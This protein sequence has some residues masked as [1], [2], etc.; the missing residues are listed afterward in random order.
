MG[1]T[2]TSM[3]IA[4]QLGCP[5]LDL[6][7]LTV[8]QATH[9]GVLT[10]S[11]DWSS[12][13]KFMESMNEGKTCLIIDALDEAPLRSGERAFY[14]FMRSLVE[15]ASDFSK[16]NHQ[17][18][19]LGRPQTV[20]Y[21]R[22]VCVDLEVPATSITLDSLS[23]E[24]SLQLISNQ[25]QQ[26][27]ISD[28]FIVHNTPAKEY[29]TAYL[30]R[31]GQILTQSEQFSAHD[32]PR[33]ADFLG[34]PPVIC[35]IAPT[36]DSHNFKQSVEKLKR[37]NAQ[38]ASH[39]WVLTSIIN[40]LLSR[41]TEKVQRHL[42]QVFRE[43][44]GENEILALYNYEEQLVRVLRLLGIPSEEVVP[45]SLPEGLRSKY[46]EA[47]ELF[48][49]DHPFLDGQDRPRPRNV[50]FSDHLRS[51]VN[52]QAGYISVPNVKPIQSDAL[53]PV[54]PFYVHFMHEFTKPKHGT[55]DGNSKLPTLRT[56]EFVEEV[57]TSWN[58]GIQGDWRAVVHYSHRATQTAVLDLYRERDL[59]S[60]AVQEKE[61]NADISFEVANPDGILQL[62][63]P[64]TNTAIVTD[65]GLFI[66]AS[67]G[68]ITLGP[69]ISIVARNIETSGVSEVI[70][71]TSSS[72][73]DEYLSDPALIVSEDF[74]IAGDY[75]VHMVGL[76]PLSVIAPNLD[77]RWKAFMPR[78]KS[79]DGLDPVRIMEAVLYIRR[80][81][82]SFRSINGVPAIH[83]DKFSR[84]VLG[85]NELLKSVSDS[86][87]EADL[88]ATRS[89][90]VVMN[91][92]E[93]ANLGISYATYGSPD[94]MDKFST[95]LAFC[96]SRDPRLV[97]SLRL[98]D[99]R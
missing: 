39:S 99:P 62:R 76:Q 55:D 73:N 50:V 18:I 20:Q 74:R 32:W 8:G 1:K 93:L 78:V 44:L 60:H 31:L 90:M 98:T 56:E 91:Q 65:H 37:R 77:Q 85:R 17:F 11:L 96:L 54:G 28:T 9:S 89:G 25:L 22:D 87:H 10:R 81:L 68:S 7:H 51:M 66:D 61:L 84:H 88:I 80:I 49:A 79:I 71:R 75:K 21:L 95:A 12:S 57:I 16:P 33:V 52:S 36:L 67:G 14:A 40:D 47:L 82:S 6:A 13:G 30:F 45:A 59:A 38:A 24:S 72:R 58:K 53:L 26:T 83:A 29:W 19:V 46:E 94:W 27:S 42:S 15:D 41:E 63:S 86:M 35:A 70:I 3:A 97:H 2:F 48:V 92:S 4:E 34:Y 69:N 43:E 5:R 23:L 64:L